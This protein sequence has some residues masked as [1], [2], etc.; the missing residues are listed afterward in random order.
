GDR[1]VVEVLLPIERRRTVVR[2]HLA[3]VFRVD[4]VRE[5]LRELE[6]RLARFAPQEICKRRVRNPAR[7]RLLEAVSAAVEAFDGALAGAERLVV[8]VD[9]GGYEIR[10]LGVGAGK[11]D[12][13]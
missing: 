3:R 13:G 9:V 5:R 6:V 8:V 12:G 11:D 1:V 10:R 2:E 4:R 7:N